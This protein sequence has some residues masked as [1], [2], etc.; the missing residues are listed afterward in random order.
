VL[1]W[2]KIKK[3]NIAETLYFIGGEYQIRT[4]RLLPASQER[5]TKQANNKELKTIIQPH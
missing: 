2:G 3:G 1:Q 4:G 5:N